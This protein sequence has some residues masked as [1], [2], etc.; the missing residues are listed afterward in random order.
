MPKTK[1]D[2]DQNEDQSIKFVPRFGIFG[3]TQSLEKGLDLDELR[4]NDSQGSI[5]V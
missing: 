4:K 5:H 3:P 2:N 1:E